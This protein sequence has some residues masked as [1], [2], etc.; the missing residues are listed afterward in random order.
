LSRKF[1]FDSKAFLQQVAA[2]L[3]QKGPIEE[4]LSTCVGGLVKAQGRQAV[5]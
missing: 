1:N 3:G 5:P 4:I 2:K